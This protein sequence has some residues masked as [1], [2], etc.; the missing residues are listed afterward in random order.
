MRALIASLALILTVLAGPGAAATAEYAFTDKACK[1][2][3]P[4]GPSQ[5]CKQLGSQPLIAG[6]LTPVYITRLSNG[7]PTQFS[8]K[9]S[10]SVPMIFALSCVN[11]AANAGIKA[12]YAGVTLPLCTANGGVPGASSEQWSSFVYMVFAARS[13]SAAP[14]S[15]FLYKDV[16]KVQLNLVYLV[17]NQPQLVVSAPFVVKPHSLAISSVT[18]TADGLANPA[19]ASGAGNGFAK[20]GEAFTIKVEARTVPTVDSAGKLNPGERAPNFGNEGVR[21]LLDSQRGGDLAAR[22]TM[23]TLP[24]LS[25]GFSAPAGGVFTGT[26]FKVDD[27][28]ILAVTPVLN[29][30]LGAGPPV[31][32]VSTTIGRFYPDH[33]DTSTS[34]PLPC[35]PHMNCPVTV[36]GAAY[37]GQPFAV[38]VEPKNAAGGTVKNYVGVLARPIT[39]AA[40]TQVGGAVAATGVLTDGAI[41]VASMLATDPATERIHATP[42]FRFPTGFSNTRPRTVADWSAPTPIYLRASAD[43]NIAGGRVTVSS[44]RASGSVEGGVTVVSGRLALNNSQGSELLKMPVRLEAQYWAATGRWE[45]SYTDSASVVQSGGIT[46]DKCLKALKGPAF[47]PPGVPCKPVLGVTANL[48]VTLDKGVGTIWL[49]APGV[50]NSGSAQ[51]QMD[52]PAWLPGTIGSAVFGVY[53][54]PWIYLREVY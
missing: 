10:T 26:A 19:A 51:F 25:G 37:S 7:V 4:F 29:D 41:A 50:G 3:K 44:L 39:L 6:E 43:E 53:K 13:P 18:R 33:F 35:A 34:G 21:V 14:A 1:N 42:T 5:S 38:K 30:Y 48:P 20:A 23:A 22:D 15:G 24:V 9:A 54:S 40:Y 12:T 36:N 27:V 31:A 45:T 8:A 2:G 28:G 16:G 11:P 52:N 49:K 32:T 46:F 17:G 47:P